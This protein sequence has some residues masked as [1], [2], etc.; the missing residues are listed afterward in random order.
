MPNYLNTRIP[1]TQV[2][3]LMDLDKDEVVEGY[4]DGFKNELCGDNRSRS[5]WHGWRN[6]RVDGKHAVKDSAQSALAHSV[7]SQKKLKN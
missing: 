4:F 2:A 6:G 3:D 1:I 5:Y 7:V